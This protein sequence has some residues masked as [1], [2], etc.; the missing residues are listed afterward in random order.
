MSVL[1]IHPAALLVSRALEPRAR[2]GVRRMGRGAHRSAEGV[3]QMP[4]ASRRGAEPAS[5]AAPALVPALFGGRHDLVRRVDRLLADKGQDATERVARQC[6][7]GDVRDGAD[8]RCNSRACGSQSSPTSCC[9]TSP[10]T[11]ARCLQRSD[12]GPRRDA[13]RRP[14]AAGHDRATVPT[15][16]SAQPANPPH[17]SH[18]SHPAHLFALDAPIAPV[19]RTRRTHR[20]YCTHC[21]ERHIRRCV[22]IARRA[23]RRNPSTRPIAGARLAT[24]G[25][26]IASAAKKTS[27]GIASVFSRAGV[28]LAR[29]F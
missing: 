23:G 21:T 9:R 14:A 19:S 26:E 13:G 27:V 25:V 11:D 7:R 8:R 28:S 22:S 2:D 10:H 5:E 17:A 16:R 4:H 24:P 15:M 18:L 3:R 12:D 20:T 6:S 1:W 29:S